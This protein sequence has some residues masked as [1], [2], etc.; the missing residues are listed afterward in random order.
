[1]SPT[2]AADLHPR[3]AATRRAALES[4][5][6]ADAP[7]LLVGSGITNVGDAAI[8]VATRRWLAARGTRVLEMDR[9]TYHAGAAARFL[10]PDGTVLLAGG[11]TIGDVWPSQAALRRRVLADL[12]AH[13]AVQLPQTVH[14]TSPAAMDAARASFA[15][16]RRLVLLL[17]DVES[18]EAVRARWGLD[19]TLAPD[20]AF[21]LGALPAAAATRDVVWLLRTDQESTRV[22]PA[23]TLGPS[24]E[25]TSI[26]WPAPRALRRRLRRL[27]ARSLALVGGRAPR[28][29][30]AIARWDAQ[31]AA[32]RLEA[33]CAL[34]ASARVVVTDRLHGSLL[35]MLLGR[36]VVVLPDRH[37]KLRSFHHTWTSGCA[38]VTW[39]DTVA[40]ARAAVAAHLAAR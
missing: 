13:R 29:R 6:P 4:L 27:T 19:A 38:D 12:P 7:A 31:E 33:G 25:P 8:A 15:A 34:L 5:V 28:R 26:D 18:V 24:P 21:F 1:M 40:E 16:H 20:L 11:G 10:G 3:L 36:P 14:F 32:D 30:A 37:G 17:R 39:C 23:R 9:R 35:A 2:R 22:T